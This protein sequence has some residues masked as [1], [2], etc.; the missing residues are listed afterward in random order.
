MLMTVIRITASIL[1]LFA[2]AGAT[3]AGKIQLKDP[4][5][6]PNDET[7]K[8]IYFFPH[9]WDPWK[10]DD[11]ALSADL[12][13]IKSLGFNT[14]CLDHE[15]SQAIDR[16]WYWLDREY[17][18]VGKENMYILPWLQLQAADRLSLMKFSHLQLKKAVTQDKQEEEDYVVYRDSE[19]RRALAHYVCVYLDRYK[20]DPALLRIKDSKGKLRPVVGLMV[21]VGW[22]NPEGLP[23]SFDEETNAYFRKWLK[24]YYHSLDHLNS[25]WGTNFK[26]FD[27]IDPCDKTV[28]NYDYPDKDNMPV[29]VK[30]HVLFRARLIA[31]ALQDVADQVRKRH[32]DVI[33]VAEVAYPFSSDHPDAKVYRWNDANEYKA[34]EFADIIFI[35]TVGN[36]SMGQVAKEQELMMM[37]GKKL[38]LAY[39]LFADATPERAAAF[40]LDCA[41]S[42]N[43]IAY[44]NW[45]EKA[46]DSSAIF[47]KPDRQNLARLMTN[48]YDMLHDVDRRHTVPA[49]TVP[50]A[51]A[52]PADSAPVSPVEADLP[53]PPEGALPPAPIEPT[54]PAPEAPSQ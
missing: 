30:E 23:L 18:L 27:E 13:K 11:A 38:V 31:D 42:A 3:T 44:Y 15:V 33:L 46:D 14:V 6:L 37:N 41:C 48:V 9:W 20:N 53:T 51:T 5:K 2:V 34:V 19:F 54:K 21:E 32:K 12:A 4:L 8:A 24:S 28:F 26:S 35:R 1:L 49:A 7:L 29:A 36:T 40:A 45:N 22:R 16:D 50:P 25:K 47:D 43:G 39:R 17:K 52:S 10:S